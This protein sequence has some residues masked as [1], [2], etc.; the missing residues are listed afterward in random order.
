MNHIYRIVWNALT[1]SWVAVAETARSH[2]KG[3][4]R[5]TSKSGR[6]AGGKALVMATL[7]I[8]GLAVTAAMAQTVPTTVV[9]TGGKTVAYTAGNG[10]PIIDINTA[11]A[12]GLSHNKFTSYN[13]DAR[14]LVLNNGNME[15]LSRLS[16]LAGQV[17]ANAN[18]IQQARV[19]LNEVVS[20]NRSVLAGFTEVLG[21]RADVVV[22]NP[23][24][25]TCSGC[26]F[27]NTDRITLTT[28]TPT[29]GADGS[30]GGF[31]VNQ[32]DVLIN[33]AGANATAQQIFDIVARSVKVDGKINTSDT[34]SLG[35]TT[36]ANSWSYNGRNV[37]GAVAPS[38][39]A[40]S[41]AIDST[42]LGGMY[43]GRINII[44]T[45][46]GVG[47]RML[48]EAAASA[49]NF[50][51]TSAGK[52]ELQA[53]LSARQDLTVTTTAASGNED[54]F[55]NGA[56]KLS[57]AANLALNAA[58]GQI[59]LAE[60]ELYAANNLT[61]TAASLSDASAA[62]KTRFAGGS[63][64]LAITGAAN[65]NG[66]AWG[67]GGALTGNANN[68]TIGNNGATLYAGTTLALSTTNNLALGTAAV[69]S[70]G[71]MTL[72]ADTGSITTATGAAQGIQSTAGNL[73]LSA[74]GGLT[75]A[76]KITADAGS[77]TGRINGTLANSGSLQAKTTLDLADKAGGGTENIVNS[78]IL[79]ADGGLTVK[80]TSI[81]NQAGGT[82]QGG[83]GTT[84]VANSLNNAGTLIASNA[85]GQAG[86][87]TLATLTNS[88]TL[89][90]AGNLD[91]N[92]TAALAN[93]G[94][95]LATNNLAV[96]AGASAITISNTGA[97]A[98]LQ[99]G[100]ALTV[101]GTNV[102]FGTQS[103]TVLGNTVGLTLASGLNNAGTLQSNDAM[104]LSIGGSLT[105]TGTL[106]AKG[107]LTSTSDTVD[108]S[109]TLTLADNAG[110][111]GTVNA[112]SLTNS[113]TL[114]SKGNATLNLN[115]A[116]NNSGKV[117]ASNNLA[118]NAGNSGL[119]ISNTGNSA[120]LQAGNALTVTGSNATFDTQQGT[121][122]GN[123]VGLTVASLNNSGTLQSNDT[124]TLAVGGASIN[125][126]TLLAKGGLT[127]NSA[128]LTNSGSLTA[129][130]VA[131]INSIIT[132]S[133]V[134]NSGTLQSKG[135][136]TLN[137]T[138]ALANTGKVLATNNLSVNAGTSA[139]TINNTGVAAALQAGNALA[140]NGTNVT[141]GTQSGTVLGKT[142][143]LTL[144]GDFT[145]SGTL[146]SSETMTLTVAGA[147][148]NSGTLLAKGGLTSNSAILNNTGILTAADVAGINSIIRANTVTNSGTLQSSG[149]LA[150]NLATALTNSGSLLSG[151]DLTL[152]GTA[153][154][155]TVN[156]NAGRLQ[157]G[158]VLDIKGSNNSR[159]VN[160]NV[161]NGATLLGGSMD[162]N[163]GTLAL[164][165]NAMVSTTGNMT[166][167]VNNLTFG[168]IN[169][170]I[171]AATS[172]T[173][174]AS[175]TTASAF[176][177]V[178]AV[179][180]G[181]DMT[182]NAPSITNTG[183]GAFSALKTLSVSA[184][185]G[186]LDNY[187]ALYAGQTLNANA[188]GTLTNRAG[189]TIDSV[190]DINIDTPAAYANAN[191]PTFTN[192]STVN[193]TG[194]INI[195]ATYFNNSIQASNARAWSA[196]G[197]GTE[198][199]SRTSTSERPFVETAG[200]NSGPIASNGCRA[201]NAV[202]VACDVG[203]EIRSNTWTRAQYFTAGSPVNA[204]KPQI[205]AGGTTTIS[206]FQTANNLGGV[207][208]GNSVVLTS[209]RGGATF[210]NDDLILRNEAGT[211]TSTVYSYWAGVAFAAARYY[212]GTGSDFSNGLRTVYP[213]GTTTLD[214]KQGMA[215]TSTGF[216]PGVGAGVF[217]N[218]GTITVT[219]T[220]SLINIG[221]TAVAA[222][223]TASPI[224]KTA[225]GAAATALASTN[226]VT[227][228]NLASPAGVAAI[229]AAGVTGITNV[230]GQAA[231]AFAGLVITLPTNPNGFFVISTNPSARYLVETNPR[232]VT[233]SGSLGSDFLL[234][235]LGIDPDGALRRL[236]D[237]NY[238]AFLV[239]QQLIA[240]TGNNILRGYGNEADQMK[241]LMDQSADQSKDAGLVFGKALTP[242]QI[243]NLKSDI[244]W[245]V[246]TTV[247]GQRVL[248]PVVYLATATRL[249]VVAGAVI[250]GTNVKMDVASLT[251]T[252]GT[253]GG[254]KSLQ[255]VSRG[256]IT[257]T[258]GTITGGNVSLR[259]TE[260]SI[261]N[262]TTVVGNIVSNAGTISATGNLALDAKKDILVS[263]GQVNA[264]GD[265]TLRA[266]RDVRFDT[267]VK[268][269]TTNSSTST[270]NGSQRTEGT[271][272]TT[273][274]TNV[275]SSLATGGRLNISS[276]RDTTI[277]G[278][279]VNAGGGMAVDAGGNFNVLARQDTST[280]RSQSTTS[281]QGVGG[282][283]MGTQTVTTD[284]FRGTNA[285]STINVGTGTQPGNMTVRAGGAMTL[286]GSNLNVSGNAVIDAQKGI[287][288][289]DG[290]NESRTTTTTNTNAF[291]VQGPT[292]SST[293]AGAGAGAG[294]N[295]KAGA[296]ASGN[297]G[298][299][300]AR[301]TDTVTQ[302]D[303]RNSVASN[304]RVGGNL[305][306]N[307][308]GTL[309]VLGS[310]L[311]VAGNAALNARD[312]IRVL[313]GENTQR[314][315]T[316]TSTTDFLKSTGD[317]NASAG[318][319]AG[320]DASGSAASKGGLAAGV[321]A[322]AKADA[323]ANAQA[324]GT[325]SVSLME[326]NVTVTQT[327]TRRS[328]GS[329]LNVGGNLAATTQG[330]L[331]VQGSNLAVG[332]NAALTARQGIR[333][334]DGENTQR[335]TTT[336]VTTS[337]LKTE[338]GAG[339]TGQANAGSGAGGDA[340]T[341]NGAQLAADK[342]SGNKAA[343]FEKPS[344]NGQTNTG[345]N[346][347][348]DAN[349]TFNT[350]LTEV[351]TTNSQSGSRQSVASGLNIGGNLNAQTEGT[352]TMRGANVAA[353]GDVAVQAKNVEVLAGR[354][355]A[356]SS[357]S[358][359]TASI[360]FFRDANANATGGAN[361]NAGLG[362]GNAENGSKASAAADAK[363][364][365]S[366]NANV[367]AVLGV[368]GEVLT[369]E[370]SSLTN[371]ASTIT[372]GR[373]V[374]IN[375]TETARFVGAQVQ[376]GGDL[377]V[378]AKNIVNLAAQDTTSNTSSR[379][380]GTAGI[381]VEGNAN[382][383]ASASV[384]KTNQASASASADANMGLLIKGSTSV[385]A[386]GST[387]QQV[388]SFTAGG[389]I[390]RTATA[391]ITDQGTQL[392]A[393]G[394]INQK[395]TTLTEID[396]RDS[397]FST[398]VTGSTEIK[399]GL[400]ARA[401]AD[402]AATG[403]ANAI[404]SAGVQGSAKAEVNVETESSSKAVTGRY[405]AG[406]N[407]N[408]ATTGKTTLIGTQFTS[409]GDTNIYAASLDFKAAQDTSSKVSNT[410]SANVGG[411]L[412]LAANTVVGGSLEGSVS[413]AGITEKTTTARAGGLSAGG[414]L[415]INVGGDAKLEGTKIQSTGQTAIAAGGTVELTAARDTKETSDYSVGASAGID[416][417]K[418]GLGVKGSVTVAGGG[419]SASTAQAGSIQ[420]GNGG[421]SIIAGKDVKLEGTAI[422]TTG[423]TA[424][425][426]GGT[427]EMKAA[428]STDISASAG[429]S[430]GIAGTKT[431]DESG[432]SN[433]VGGNV[434]ASAKVESQAV[435][436][437][438]GGGNVTIA[439]A[440]VTNQQ[441]NIETS[442]TTAVTG[443]VTN[444]ETVNVS[445]SGG[446]SGN[447]SKESKPKPEAQAKPK[448]E[449][450]PK[451]KAEPKTKTEAKPLTQPQRPPQTEPVKK[452]A[453]EL[454]KAGNN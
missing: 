254:E 253:I 124:M 50:R 283:M 407:I 310:N 33:G 196:Y 365:V 353:G 388:S 328:A 351:S 315:T 451:P 245:M 322:G 411:R 75:N 360:G 375:A 389:N 18:L 86:A 377:A 61:T 281:G 339:A 25:I 410:T 384:G 429:L 128:T 273:T 146:Q 334:L 357:S 22:A 286:Q 352:L 48:G 56:A 85:A 292:G 77:V 401:G 68:L 319:N 317:G 125:S 35:I 235:R 373:N 350:K 180:S 354:N 209:S 303:S 179:H 24:G 104:T 246:E 44:A 145:N 332:G 291:L 138:Q 166:V 396:A 82:L 163:A 118:V 420:A 355:E 114:Q 442:G 265:A 400:G 362:T 137:L 53:A 331:T 164:A 239:R 69:R 212:G 96:N 423:N 428:V 197:Y 83:A 117:L 36:G 398:S 106:L 19:I 416:S 426:A 94:K 234:K 120:V 1:A 9:P 171:V 7:A 13:V 444:Q 141:F 136:L 84:L 28:G 447:M 195:A 305:V 57:A 162:I 218:G 220:V 113:G 65:I 178:G 264:A 313:D 3:S 149:N 20:T 139:V 204:V 290:L 14:G 182:F 150:M 260:G 38:G 307:T 140:V 366:A 64:T 173:G 229:A 293:D 71:N 88:G 189:A 381:Y 130:D 161:A 168:G 147:L 46:A 427:V 73:S 399:G 188:M 143:G 268:T 144:A 111:N 279:R 251:N 105:N 380:Q 327:D 148:T 201:P 183:T 23:N 402:A 127:S 216:T 67:A 160:I 391:G 215:L 59:K 34:G 133:T 116:L 208:S 413:N 441:A 449:P 434:A 72:A 142:V 275:G 255:V 438:S 376:A 184:T 187:G 250:A 238:E 214:G 78:G 409:G 95:V 154:T 323:N 363:A 242:D 408:S 49:D 392:A 277:A 119:A 100:N 207:I 135:D 344:A 437:K 62:A 394:N 103:G 304:F 349:G 90:S 306:A 93:T 228:A 311:A 297:G 156:A 157:A 316:T 418:A 347:T 343:S 424:L 247:A 448:A 301:V 263:G 256:D 298:G 324:A 425:K 393:G 452:P 330:V 432:M 226:G 446:L 430:G 346:A 152:R 445:L 335:T 249:A 58:G 45:E 270:D 126:G 387:T 450:K 312:G 241:R 16:Q 167:G 81:D 422:E 289:L 31:N 341:G 15:Q 309:T 30:L 405:T 51:L 261:N 302:T 433:S 299:S 52:I 193:A 257:N 101:N 342:I 326:N 374:T 107:G 11:N 415:N 131:G 110:A 230:N 217:A 129:A 43:S 259:S 172:G 210:T 262:I 321:A 367:T 186:D 258:A 240:Q 200:W 274:T 252:G 285:G 272:T 79:L 60:G 205:I 177:N 271:S 8:V 63:N 280:T 300:L 170:R 134:T 223:K 359:V 386:D 159:D 269:E 232:F 74:G 340:A 314:T 236:G 378:E 453:G 29:F 435:S 190:G 211:L 40:A 112:K 169:S 102:T 361:A 231:V 12:A 233:G 54:L 244:V 337:V 414:N 296:E 417:G 431:K 227:A 47:V 213:N 203:T 282:G 10:V 338:L 248:A 287:N 122:L 368:R 395:A 224:S 345:A 121:V 364:G 348:A 295:A 336:S 284:S 158:G 443:N 185:T 421:I 132:A 294:A 385:K 39:A 109:G 80:A 55:V 5:A 27:I 419:G 221:G 21:G 153:G 278:S 191:T 87:L 2:G 369:S 123:T 266:G 358:T 97:A 91:L 89:Q 406:G 181:G 198:N 32:G 26:G 92:L 222:P 267:I 237:A 318:A 98:V 397:R 329:S 382:A 325:A 243:A 439:G 6:K 308:Q 108:N 371:T 174:S 356:S 99:A 288:V 219:G 383:Q 165:D 276:D 436:I 194:N 151:G 176:N 390:T 370:S 440:N 333:V 320:A 70:A 76:G 41:Y 403:G 4:K 42:V 155:Y 454:G 66:T 37:T 206:N 379:T 192:N 225:T 372:G 412:E 202:S 404:A 115:T 199:Y 17:A 175:V